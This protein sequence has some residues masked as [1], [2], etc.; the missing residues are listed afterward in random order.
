MELTRRDVLG[1]LSAAGVGSVSGCSDL[2][3]GGAVGESPT[4]DDPVTDHDVE[5]LVALAEVV[6]PSGVTEIGSFVREYSVAR[7]RDDASYA[8]GVGETVARLDDYVA[9]WH[10]DS[11]TDLAPSTRAD[12]L[13]QMG[14]DAADPDPGGV[15]SERIRYYLVNE[16]LYA[17][18]A[19]PTGAGLVGLENPPGHP[20]GTTSYQEGPHE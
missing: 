1:A 9:E 6:Y 14:V 18:Y 12:V 16:L 11:Y 15:A 19:S 10:D 3:E 8:R 4:D 13:D 7:V 2:L 20:G 5:T 17:F